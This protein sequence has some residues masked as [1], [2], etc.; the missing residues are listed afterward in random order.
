MQSHK[1]EKQEGDSKKASGKVA[2]VHGP[3]PHGV[4]LKAQRSHTPTR[5]LS[6]PSGDSNASLIFISL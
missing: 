5:S 1:E 6:C 4:T 3:G 2:F